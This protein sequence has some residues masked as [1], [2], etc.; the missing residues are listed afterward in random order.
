MLHFIVF[1]YGQ[2]NNAFNIN[3]KNIWHVRVYKQ[4]Q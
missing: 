2:D 4:F 1:G 3:S